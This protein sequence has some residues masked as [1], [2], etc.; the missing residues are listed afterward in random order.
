VTLVC[1]HWRVSDIPSTPA[2]KASLAGSCPK[3]F[4]LDSE[5]EEHVQLVDVTGSFP[6]SL[7]SGPESPR[8]NAQLQKER[9]VPA[10]ISVTKLVLTHAL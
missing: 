4:P 6:I 1:R 8:H 9:G 3:L 5:A 2:S 7:S 10:L